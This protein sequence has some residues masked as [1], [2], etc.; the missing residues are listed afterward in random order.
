MNRFLLLLIC[1]ATLLSCTNKER[2]NKDEDCIE[3]ESAEGK[4]FV[5]LPST[6]NE[7]PHIFHGWTS[8]ITYAS[9]NEEGNIAGWSKWKPEVVKYALYLDHG[10]VS[11]F[12]D[13]TQ[14]HKIE[15]FLGKEVREGAVCYNVTVNDFC[16][17]GGYIKFCYLN[18]GIVQ[19]YVDYPGLLMAYNL[20]SYMSEEE[21]YERLK[22]FSAEQ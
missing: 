8:G 12:A 16:E 7:M 17:L 21:L 19:L 4:Q 18:N 10:I 15:E 5:A 9:L 6:A 14:L 3:T 22:K 13:S 11:I 20:K 1:L 2:R